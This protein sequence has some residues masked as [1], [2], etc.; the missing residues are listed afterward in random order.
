M[1]R[2]R[3]TA[4]VELAICI[5]LLFLLIFGSI[6]VTNLI[7]LR[8]TLVESGYEGALLGSQKNTT[9]AEILQRVQVALVA[10]GIQGGVVSVNVSSAPDYDA[11]LAGD[12]FTVH[13]EAPT[14]ANIPGPNIFAQFATVDAD[15]VGHKQ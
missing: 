3:G 15:I 10:R 2:R 14:G 7:F 11:L 4:V 5:P 1:L 13:V 6:E 8:Q 9:E 12:T